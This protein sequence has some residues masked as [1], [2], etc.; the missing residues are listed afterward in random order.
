MCLLASPSLYV[1]LCLYISAWFPLGGL[2]WNL[3]L[4]TYVKICPE[5]PNLFKIGQ[6]CWHYTWRPKCI[7]LLLATLNQLELLSK[8]GM[9]SGS[10]HQRR[11]KT[12]LNFFISTTI[13]KS[14][15]SE[16]TQYLVDGNMYSRS[17][18]K[19]ETRCWDPMATVF[20]STTIL[21]TQNCQWRKVV[22][23]C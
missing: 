23:G 22:V 1:C 2:L 10:R 14:C 18:V 20:S 13:L 16:A 8:S 12:L 11:C 19:K 7:V 5:N 21:I 15:I 4:G 9:V 3:I 6:N 17:T